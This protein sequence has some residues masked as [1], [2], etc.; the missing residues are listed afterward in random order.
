MADAFANASI[1]STS[2]HTRQDVVVFADVRM[3]SG[4]E[5]IIVNRAKACLSGEGGTGAFRWRWFSG[6]GKDGCPSCSSFFLR[7][8]RP[9]LIL[10]ALFDEM[11]N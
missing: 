6:Y 5:A 4:Y 11:N 8:L 10:K 1:V 3:N 9:W 7:L 2:E